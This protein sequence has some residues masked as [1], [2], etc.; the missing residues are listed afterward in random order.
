LSVYPAL[1]IAQQTD[2]ALTD[3]YTL[4]GTWMT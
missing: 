3:D 1:E 4:T 2:R